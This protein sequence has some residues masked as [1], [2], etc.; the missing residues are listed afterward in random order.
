[1]A[2]MAMLGADSVEYHRENVVARADDFPGQA[3][4]Y[5]ASRGETPL[6]WGG[7]GAELLGLAGTVTDAQYGFVYG[8]G[9]ACDPTTGERLVATR[10]PG[11]DLVI[12]AHK[13]VAELG[14]I[15]RADDMHAILDAERDATMGYLDEMVAAMGGRRGRARLT[16]QTGG[17]LYAHTR[18]ATSRAGDPC[19]HD[20]VLVANVD[21]MRDERGG[22]KGLDTM[23]VRDH[24]HAATMVGRVAAARRA[25]E[26]GYAIERDDGA[27][28]RL[29]HWRIVG[30]P[31]EVEQLHSKRSGEIHEY[32]KDQAYS[33]WRAR[34]LAAT[35]T[36]DVKR[37]T[38][39]TELVAVWQR[40][41][42][43]AGWSPVTILEAVIDAGDRYQQRDVIRPVERAEIIKRVI[44]PDGLLARAKIFHRRDVVVA[45]A[46]HLFGRPPEE[47]RRTVEEVLHHPEVVRLL[48][49][50]GTRGQAWSL[51]SVIATEHAIADVV[52]RGTADVGAVTIPDHLVTAAVSTME[53]RLGRSL[54]D[55][56][57]DAVW[58]IC[59]NAERVNLVLGVAG[60]G[61]TT[62]LRCVAD[63]YRAAGH[64]VLGTATSGQA[65]RTLGR[66]AG[67]DDS[68]TL[69]SLCW[70]LD[71]GQL[72]LAPTDLV[73][74]DEAGMT[75]DPDLL[76][77]LT[78][79]EIAGTKVTLVGDDRQLSAVGPGG[80]FGALLERHG[81]HAYLLEE[82]LRQ[83]DAA[84]RQALEELRSG[85][86]ARA[87][88]WYLDND[89]VHLS[90]HR[91]EALSRM[92]DAWA[93]DALEGN[94][95]AMF[96]W[97]RRNVAAL[98]ELARERWKSE[99]QLSGPELVA[100]GGRTYQPGD[101]I[102]TLSP[103]RDTVTSERGTV[104]AV[105]SD[106]LI[107][108]MDDGRF[109]RLERDDLDRKHLDHGYATTVHRAQGATVDRAHRFEDGGG[110]EL[111]YVALSRAR[112]TTSLWMVA[113][114]IPQARDDLQREWSA[115]ARARWVID[116]TSLDQRPTRPWQ[117]T[118]RVLDR[119]VIEAERHAINSVMPPDP[120][121]QLHAI[122]R[123]LADMA[124]AERDLDRGEGVWAKTPI[125]QQV[126]RLT[127]IQR[128][129][130]QAET[131]ANM[132]DMPRRVRRDWRR[133]AVRYTEAERA[134]E[135]H[136][137]Q[138][139]EPARHDLHERQAQL[140]RQRSKL[141]QVAGQRSDWLQQH[142]E[143]A[144]RLE[145]FDREL[146]SID[147]APELEKLARELSRG[148]T[149]EHSAE[150]TTPEI[151]RSRELGLEL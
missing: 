84:E 73:L 102:V 149:I 63:A 23:Q 144:C 76:R 137:D 126:R 74:L 87:L 7:S 67:L 31:H 48:P 30:I 117:E 57:L 27:S 86:V 39:V 33:G 9:G 21:D 5:Y 119:A 123:Q 51:A 43:T 66:E 69:A 88:S 145:R 120:R 42:V 95:V 65:A 14:V 82:N 97:Q 98:N 59:T 46:P 24:L 32:L 125:G 127:D 91:D 85:N 25:V 53:Q 75:D 54:T 113:D 55:G 29:G 80:G 109:V 83:H 114:D 140:K 70:R 96:A 135:T 131:F 100:P 58:G 146:E 44:D 105:S 15:G 107:S 68:R 18:H 17:L 132:P 138:L 62:A 103:G 108:R 45:V 78:A 116:T 112:Q 26:L 4:G 122:H 28:G 134:A 129:R 41:L 38:P 142:P 130:E 77:V 12:S 147:R 40:E 3:L 11:M 118:A 37:H 99:G 13:S 22:W 47:L 56:Q 90:S 34:Q 128:Q 93:D 106:A 89:R 60:A 36:R 52:A 121:P 6:Q 133:N 111:V 79:C 104:V 64:R 16:T 136:L 124:Q 50:P 151:S 110:R 1:M 61:K 115:E 2:W 101:W 143:A 92:V 20:H 8:L 94:N 49:S 139:V 19:P 71:H 10:R 141:Q 148:R 35:K 150:H 72:E 81:G